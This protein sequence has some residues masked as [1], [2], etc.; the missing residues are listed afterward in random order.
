MRWDIGACDEGSGLENHP[1][2]ASRPRAAALQIAEGTHYPGSFE[3]DIIAGRMAGVIMGRELPGQRS[4]FERLDSTIARAVH[5]H[6]DV[7]WADRYPITNR[8]GDVTI[9]PEADR[10][11]SG[12]EER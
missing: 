8:Q 12:W 3:G 11:I 7:R 5:R 4:D 6:W 10:E 9:A 1:G 2:H